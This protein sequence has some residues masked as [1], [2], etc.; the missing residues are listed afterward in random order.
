MTIHT[1]KLPGIIA[2]VLLTVRTGTGF[3]EYDRA[4][5]LADVTGTPF[6]LAPGTDSKLTVVCF[7]GTEC[8]L[9]RLYGPRLSRLARE[10]ADAGVQFIGINSNRQDSMTDIREYV[11]NYD[12]EFP[13]MRD[14]A[15]NVADRYLA[16]RTPEVYVLD[17]GLN[18]L[19]RGRIDDQ[20]APGVSRRKPDRQD[21][22]R[23]LTELLAGTPVTIARTEAAGCLI[24]RVRQREQPIDNAVT[25]AE[26]VVPVLH[27]HCIECHRA[28]EIG[29]FGMERYDEVA[30]WADTM[31]ETIDD[32]RMPPWHADPLHGEFRNTRTMAEADK[33]VLRDW[34]AGGLAKGDLS[35]VPEPPPVVDGWQLLKEPDVVLE[36]RAR[37]FVVAAEGTVEY[38]YF[39]VDPGFKEDKWI[40]DAQVMPGNR[41]VVHHIIVFIRAP[42]L[43]QTSGVGWLTAYVPGAR[44]IELPKGRA[45]LVPA[46]SKFVF[47]MHYTPTGRQQEDISSLGLVFADESSVTH[48]VYTIAGLDQEFEI[49]P[50][51]PCHVVEGHVGR[52][53]QD[54]ELLGIAP[55]MHYRGKS[56]RLW[57]GRGDDAEVLLNVPKYDF[58]W[59]HIYQ[60]KKPLPLND[61]EQLR[62][63]VAFDNS[64]SNP[65]NPD[66]S[67][68]VSWGDQSWEEM[69]VAFFDVAVPR[70]MSGHRNTS[71]RT[72]D[73]SKPTRQDR[74]D[75]YVARFFTALDKNGDGKVAESETPI[76]V[77]RRN[78]ERFD[79]DDNGY[80]TE[81]EIVQFAESLFVDPSVD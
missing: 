1:S 41:S 31:L 67:R 42:K 74:I 75:A 63:S 20:Y 56:F 28:G 69:A 2:V 62:F 54:A 43:S 81:S 65:V 13:V 6:V 10:F 73:A 48:E 3:A 17:S 66:S 57:N 55:H 14:V 27:R 45:R 77:R 58:N 50:G 49:P 44:Q 36:M 23:A 38:Q 11:R 34:I 71:V 24:G 32:G 5:E 64:D 68:W 53:P 79:R 12:I 46:G 16:T 60:L 61:I 72:V 21:L 22:R 15:N 26:H 19:Y 7:L 35:T 25:F 18:V 40:L 37:P 70:G 76:I 52:L 78:F 39:V 29:P 59:Q 80:V 8:P 9:A 47:Q 33:Q 51:E 30:G 4:F